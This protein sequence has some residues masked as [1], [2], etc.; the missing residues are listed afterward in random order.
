L[1]A[2]A[3]AWGATY[4]TN[5]II[6]VALD[7]DTGKIWFSKNNTWQ[8]GDPNTGTSPAATLAIG[9]TWVPILG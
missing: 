3:N 1:S 9:S 5:D 2:S 7:A 4:T 8:T 6:G